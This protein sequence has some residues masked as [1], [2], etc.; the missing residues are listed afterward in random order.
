MQQARGQMCRLATPGVVK[1]GG[2]ICTLRAARQVG[3]GTPCGR[4]RRRRA[5]LDAFASLAPRTRPTHSPPL[6]AQLIDLR[7]CFIRDTRG[8]HPPSSASLRGSHQPAAVSSRPSRAS[9]D[10]HAARRRTGSGGGDEAPAPCGNW[11]GCAQCRCGR[12]ARQSAALCSWTRSRTVGV[13]VGRRPRRVVAFVG[14]PEG[15]GRGD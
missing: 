8:I 10:A 15:H 13:V 9:T 1:D 5:W 2:V 4:T 3:D 7:A 14:P 6:L 11:Q 12:R